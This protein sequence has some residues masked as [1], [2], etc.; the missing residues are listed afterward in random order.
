MIKYVTR[1]W[2]HNATWVKTRT[3]FSLLFPLE[4]SCPSGTVLGQ[5]WQ[6]KGQ[7]DSQ[8]VTITKF[9][10]W[11]PLD[12]CVKKI[13]MCLICAYRYIDYALFSMIKY[14][15]RHWHHNASWVKTRTKFSLL[16]PSGTVRPTMTK[17]K[18][19]RQSGCVWYVFDMWVGHTLLC[20]YL[21][22][23]LSTNAWQHYFIARGLMPNSRFTASA[24]VWCS[25]LLCALPA[26]MQ[27]AVCRGRVYRYKCSDVVLKESYLL[28][29]M[30]H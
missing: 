2:H 13:R 22:V 6:R 4:W 8:D 28:L 21:Y 27:P 16:F 30:T 24:L 10:L 14:V 17:E 3:K 9:S 15:T 26:T 19:E 29:L 12:R 7:R 11:V 5:L 20:F 23:L 25:A 18:S 1:H